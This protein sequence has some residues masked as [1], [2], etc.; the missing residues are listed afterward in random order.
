[1]VHDQLLVYYLMQTVVADIR[2]SRLTK[3]HADA[4]FVRKVEYVYSHSM[5]AG[6]LDEMSYTTRLTSGTSLTMR[7]LMRAST[8]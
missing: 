1:M 7:L 2:R 4:D 3:R 5:V 8:S 6:G